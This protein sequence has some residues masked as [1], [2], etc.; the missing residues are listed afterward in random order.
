MG[1]AQPVILEHTHTDPKTRKVVDVLKDRSDANQAA[2]DEKLEAH[3]GRDEDEMLTGAP[4]KVR[5]A[6][7][8]HMIPMLFYTLEKAWRVKYAQFLKDAS[9][10]RRM[11]QNK[12]KDDPASDEQIDRG[13]HQIDDMIDLL[14]DYWGLDEEARKTI[15]LTA[16]RN[17]LLDA[18]QKVVTIVSPL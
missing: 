15:E 2:Y 10:L 7:K 12:S 17:E 1:N 9:Q 6:G 14:F 11:A 4:I 5:I 16:T 3:N 8:T 18:A 13:L